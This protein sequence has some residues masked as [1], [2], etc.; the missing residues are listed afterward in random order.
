MSGEWQISKSYDVYVVLLEMSNAQISNQPHKSSK[1]V[2]KE[3]RN[4]PTELKVHLMKGNL[5]SLDFAIFHGEFDY[6][7][8]SQ[9]NKK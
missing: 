2:F 1:M 4:A 9:N 3:P 8:F 6:I 5:I 7:V